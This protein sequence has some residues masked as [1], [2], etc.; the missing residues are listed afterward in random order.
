MNES[1]PKS[2]RS[3]GKIATNQSLIFPLSSQ[4]PC[5]QWSRGSTALQSSRVGGPFSDCPGKT[6]SEGAGPVPRCRVTVSLSVWHQCLPRGGLLR[7][8][9]VSHQKIRPFGF[10][11]PHLKAFARGMLGK[12]HTLPESGGG[13]LNGC[14]AVPALLEL[15]VLSALVTSHGAE[16]PRQLG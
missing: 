16:G 10:L 11:L 8:S 12:Y 4:P 9:C 15:E 2:S 1:S 3:L 6:A 13:W 5:S 7:N 14:V